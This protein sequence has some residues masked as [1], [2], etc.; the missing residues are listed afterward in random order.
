MQDIQNQKVAVEDRVNRQNQLGTSMTKANNSGEANDPKAL[1]QDIE[2]K[3]RMEVPAQ[4]AKHQSY[5]THKGPQS[6]LRKDEYEVFRQ[7]LT[8]A[9]GLSETNA[10]IH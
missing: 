8:K 10:I 3:Q 2:Q 7:K 6:K 5:E 9:T 4:K 1:N